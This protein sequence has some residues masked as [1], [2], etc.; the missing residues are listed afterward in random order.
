M[1][2]GMGKCC[3]K[4]VAAPQLDLFPLHKKRKAPANPMT[5]DDKAMAKAIRIIKK[6]KPDENRNRE[7]S[8]VSS[9]DKV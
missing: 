3:E 6:I 7:G 8:E 5:K 2:L 4:K 9:A 1:K